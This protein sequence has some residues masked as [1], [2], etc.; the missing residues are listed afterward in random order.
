MF[1][2]KVQSSAVAFAGAVIAAAIFIGAAVEPIV[3]LA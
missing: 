1:I 2:T 3:T